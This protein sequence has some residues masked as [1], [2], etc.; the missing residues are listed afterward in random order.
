MAFRKLIYSLKKQSSTLTYSKQTTIA[1]VAHNVPMFSDKEL[2]QI[3]SQT[4]G[5][6]HNTVCSALFEHKKS[7]ITK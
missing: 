4:T 6:G 2:D 7:Y 5:M 1:A 3:I